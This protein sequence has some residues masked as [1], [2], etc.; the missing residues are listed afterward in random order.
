MS[1]VNWGEGCVIYLYVLYWQTIYIQ[2]DIGHLS[3]VATALPWLFKHYCWKYFMFEGT[4]I[5]IYQKQMPE[6]VSERPGWDRARIHQARFEGTKEFPL[7]GSL[8]DLNSACSF[9]DTF[10]KGEDF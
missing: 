3:A 8:G 1:M 10:W 4:L 9:E 6:Y 2:M 5:Q 7:W